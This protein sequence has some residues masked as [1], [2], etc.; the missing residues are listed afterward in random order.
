MINICRVDSSN[1]N[2][3]EFWNRGVQLVA[4]NYQT[5]GLMMDLQV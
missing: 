4:L 1:M 3:Q 2:P 5:P